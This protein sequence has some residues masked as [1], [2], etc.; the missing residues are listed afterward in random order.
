MPSQ[1]DSRM[2]E[3]H[4]RSI[5]NMILKNFPY[6]LPQICTLKNHSKCESN[7]SLLT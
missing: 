3:V 2:L 1:Q 6:L 7:K 4:V 5:L